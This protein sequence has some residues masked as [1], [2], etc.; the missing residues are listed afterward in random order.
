MMDQNSRNFSFPAK[1]GIFLGLIG[2][3]LVI[4]TA[5]SAGA[6][7]IMTGRPILS[8]ESD[9]LNPKYYNAIMAMQ[10]ISTLFIFF[11]PVY[12]FALICYRN[13]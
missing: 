9:M 3:G 8:L 6:W 10:V 7:I 1:F 11:L 2:A 5:I 4:G 13:P 12:F